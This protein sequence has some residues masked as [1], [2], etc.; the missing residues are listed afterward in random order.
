MFLVCCLFVC[1]TG[2]VCKIA[3]VSGR[4]QGFGGIAFLLEAVE[5]YLPPSS[6]GYWLNF[7]E[8]VGLRFSFP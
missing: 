3:S 5:E 2:S 1:F 6:S 8:I 7:V 4:S